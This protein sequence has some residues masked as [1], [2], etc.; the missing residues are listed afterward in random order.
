[1]V[2]DDPIGPLGRGIRSAVSGQPVLRGR[3]R[4]DPSSR[5]SSRSGVGA[6][7]WLPRPLILAQ[8][9]ISTRARRPVP[10]A[11]T[12]RG[13]VVDRVLASRESN[14]WTDAPDNAIIDGLVRVVKPLP[15]GH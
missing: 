12:S 14:R 15:R 7:W 6:A 5:L 13:S 9:A 8:G 2:R 4:T 3:R 1:M 11:A 10:A